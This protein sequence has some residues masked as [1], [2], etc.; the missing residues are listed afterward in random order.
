MIRNDVFHAD[1]LSLRHLMGKF[2]LW[3]SDVVRLCAVSDRT[4]KRYYDNDHA[5]VMVKRLLWL[6]CTGLP[7]CHGW[8]DMRIDKDGILHT[9]TGQKLSSGQ[10]NAVF[11]HE[12]RMAALQDALNE[13]TAQ[14]EAVL[15]ELNQRHFLF[16]PAN[17]VLDVERT[18]V[19]Q[20]SLI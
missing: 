18:T 8:Q 15:S 13:K 11:W 17:D 9:G 20:L 6:Y 14:L 4:A 10:I 5:P 7:D 1:N 3:R 19:R 16:T 2:C 12:S